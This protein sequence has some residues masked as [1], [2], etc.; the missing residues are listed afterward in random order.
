MRLGLWQKTAVYLTFV[1]VGLSGFAWFVLHDFIDE[2]PGELARWLLILH[3]VSAFAALMVFGSLFPRHMR[4][5]WLNRRNVVSGGFTA[6]IMTAL[7]VTA[8]LLYYGG[9]EVRWISRWT[10][11][12]VGSLGFTIIPLHVVLGRRSRNPA[13]APCAGQAID[14]PG[15]YARQASRG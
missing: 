11:I 4:L 14:N 2:E 3:G 1:A 7:I 13:T 10:H 6:L 8:L 15:R 9:E 12:V 5:G